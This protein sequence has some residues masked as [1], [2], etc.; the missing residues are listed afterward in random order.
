MVP[1]NPRIRLPGDARPSLKERV[2]AL[3]YVPTL[4]RMVWSTHRGLTGSMIALRLVRSII[5]ILALWTGK[6]IIDAVVATQRTGAADWDGLWR[7]VALELGIVVTGEIL[8]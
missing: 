4:L 5:P 8:A 6:L 2:N 7:L 1:P 3:R